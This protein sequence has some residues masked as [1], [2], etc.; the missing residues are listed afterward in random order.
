MSFER[1]SKISAIGNIDVKT[2]LKEYDDMIIGKKKTF[3]AALMSKENGPTLCASL[4]RL[5]F[6]KYLGWT[7]TQIRD[8]LTPE[9]VERMCLSSLINRIPSPPEILR[10]S[11][12][13]F[14]AWYLYPETRNSTDAELI[15]KVYQD[16]VTG[17]IQKFP[18]NYFEDNIGHSRAKYLFVIM[19]QE[20]YNGVF[21]SVEDMY[22]FFASDDGKRAVEEHKLKTP[23]M[24]W[25]GN[26]L[27]YFHDSIPSS[28]KSSKTDALYR[29][30]RE[31]KANLRNTLNIDQINNF[32]DNCEDPQADASTETEPA[33]T[34]KAYSNDPIAED[35]SGL[36][37]DEAEDDD[38]LLE[39]FQEPD[40]NGSNDIDYKGVV[41]FE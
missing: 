32:F 24:E 36:D 21:E 3:S 29:A 5:I 25:Y 8:L 11:E 37:A 27:D 7:P 9:V 30:L 38:E 41:S 26:A 14:V 34:E 35:I 19:L 39:N 40:E 10:D 31:K 20:Y 2:F 4:L 33:E 23:M 28:M 1:E 12:L 13:Y 15:S 16:L 18:K 6:D 17:K 22:R